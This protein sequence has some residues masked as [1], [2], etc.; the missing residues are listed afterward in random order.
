VCAL[1]GVTER[2]DGSGLH[3]VL[4]ANA[5]AAV[6]KPSAASLSEEARGSRR[7]AEAWS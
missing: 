7:K 6:P 2:E 1:P 5:G 3:G 4:D